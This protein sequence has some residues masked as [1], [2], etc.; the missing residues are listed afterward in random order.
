MCFAAWPCSA[1]RDHAPTRTDG[2]VRKLLGVDYC[3]CASKSSGPRNSSNFPERRGPSDC[4]RRVRRVSLGVQQRASWRVGALAYLADCISLLLPP[5]GRRDLTWC[6]TV[7]RSCLCSSNLAPTFGKPEMHK[8]AK[9]SN[10]DGTSSSVRLPDRGIPTKMQ[11]PTSSA[12]WARTGS[13][14][15]EPVHDAA[16]EFRLSSDSPHSAHLAGQPEAS[17]SCSITAD[18]GATMPRVRSQLSCPTRQAPTSLNRLRLPALGRAGR[19]R[20]DPAP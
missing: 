13:A 6:E 17:A 4:R 8:G 2:V 3:A 9:A 11:L 15:C 14:T 18:I 5:F 12:A 19:P 7:M 1:S 10:A 16:L 20:G